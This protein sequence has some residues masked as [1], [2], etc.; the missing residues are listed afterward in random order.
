MSKNG[1]YF[2]EKTAKVLQKLH[3]KLQVQEDV[4]ILGKLSNKLRQIDVLIE[5]TQFEYLIFECKDHNRP[6][7]LDTFG[8]FTSILDDIKSRGKAAVVSNSPYTDGV[9]NM[10]TAKGIDLLHV[11]DTNDPKVRTQLKAPI[12]LH[13][14]KLKH[15]QFQFQTIENFSGIP[16]NPI[17]V[18]PHFEG[19]PKSYLKHLWNETNLLKEITGDHKFELK[20]SFLIA[21]DGSKVPFNITFMY[22]V[23][24]EHYLGDLAIQN[25]QGIYNIQKGTYQTSSLE[26]EPLEAYEVEKV[27][28]KI[29]DQEAKEAHVS[30]GFGCKSLYPL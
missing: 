30:M 25:T 9:K 6:V 5:P 28:K 26:T 21:T 7:D 11:I 17:I 12:L 20:D 1:K 16:V 22:G 27:W 14:T 4:K 8:V 23:E 18:G 13:D 24:E 15:M 2:E 10:A 29:T 3:P 19:D